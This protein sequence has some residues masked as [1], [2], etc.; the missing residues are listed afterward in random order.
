MNKQDAIEK[1]Y[2]ASWDAKRAGV[3]VEFI[4]DANTTRPLK[5]V[6][7]AVDKLSR[8]NHY[9]FWHGWLSIKYVGSNGKK[10]KTLNAAVKN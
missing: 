1:I 4:I 10:Y 9:G 6:K 2:Q 3:K 5:T 7:G 8:M